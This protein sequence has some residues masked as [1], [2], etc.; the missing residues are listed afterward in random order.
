MVEESAGGVSYHPETYWP[1]RFASEGPDYVAKRGD[2]DSYE[3]Q[4]ARFSAALAS[5]VPNGR[6]LLD[7]G[8]GVGRFAMMLS[9]KTQDYV[10][11]DIVAGALSLMPCGRAIELA[12]H[13]P[14]DGFD[15]VVAITVL[16][17]IVSDS[18]FAHWCGELGRVLNPGGALVV[19]EDNGAPVMAPHMRPRGPEA[20]AAITGVGKFETLPAGPEHWAGIAWKP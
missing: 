3:R 7:F 4:H 9:Y 14:E 12:G 5:L 2:A 10:G 18:D 11:A 6:K 15:V 19:I 8:C 16:Q 20:I 17:H 1:A 13:I